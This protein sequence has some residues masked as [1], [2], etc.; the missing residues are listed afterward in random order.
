[1]PAYVTVQLDVT[2]PATFGE[3]RKVGG[4]A[5]AKHGGKALS[6]G[7]AEMLFDASVGTHPSV[8][9]EFPDEAA[10][11]AWLD[12][13]ELAEAHALRNKGA[14]ASVTLLKAN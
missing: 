13:P 7:Q 8:L 12:D 10:V 4:P 11:R 3:Y 1:M 9:L 5:V 2:D 14:K 6:S